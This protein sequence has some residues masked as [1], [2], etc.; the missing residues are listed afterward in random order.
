MATRLETTD[1]ELKAEL[2]AREHKP[3]PGDLIRISANCTVVVECLRDGVYSD[4]HQLFERDDIAEF[5]ID[6]DKDIYVRKTR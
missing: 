2:E 6:E 3:Q 4:E 1:E 5:D